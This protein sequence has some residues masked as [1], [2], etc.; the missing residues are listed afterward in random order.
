MSEALKSESCDR[1]S[2]RTGIL[3]VL[4]NSRSKKNASLVKWGRF[5]AGGSEITAVN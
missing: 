1:S 4:Q 5:L 2:R 3:P